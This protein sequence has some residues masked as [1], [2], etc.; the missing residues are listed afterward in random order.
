MQSSRLAGI[1]AEAYPEIN[2]DFQSTQYP[3]LYFIG[4]LTHSID[5]ERSSGGFI[6]GFRYTGEFFRLLPLHDAILVMLVALQKVSVAA[7]ALYRLLEWRNHGVRWPSITKTLDQLVPSLL[8]RANEG[9]GIYHMFGFL[10]DLVIY[11][12]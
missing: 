12:R 4:A 10:C 6:N 1:P 2:M 8:K 5:Y 9:S 3:G 11:E 7:R